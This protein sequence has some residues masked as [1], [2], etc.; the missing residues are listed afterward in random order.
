MINFY[1]YRPNGQILFVGQC[2]DGQL[3]YQ[4]HEGVEFAEGLAD[5]K[6][7]YRADDGT[8]QTV[9]P[10]PGEYHDFNYDTKSW[11]PNETAAVDGVRAERNRLLQESDWT[12]TAS[13]PARLGE[14]VYQAWQD[15]RQALRDVTSQPG[16]PFDVAWPAPPY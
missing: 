12:D 15:Y 11:V 14:E 9:P 4:R 10:N 16:F 6:A 8:L 13:A 2:P 3:Q 5:F 1:A 7:Q